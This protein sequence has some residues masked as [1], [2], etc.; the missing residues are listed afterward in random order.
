MDDPLFRAIR[1]G[2]PADIQKHLASGTSP[3]VLSADGRYRP[4]IFLAGLNMSETYR[5]EMLALLLQAGKEPLRARFESIHAKRGLS[6]AQ[7]D[8]DYDYLAQMARQ[9]PSVRL[10]A[11]P[12]K[13]GA[14]K[15]R[16]V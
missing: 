1:Q 5:G 2:T 4:L 16:P 11:R 6:A 14:P 12:K 7:A 10:S 3:D 8:D 9:N 15:W 13:Q